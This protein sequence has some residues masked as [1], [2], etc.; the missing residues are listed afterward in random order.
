MGK[1]A[2]MAM[3][4]VDAYE[5]EWIFFN[6]VITQHPPFFLVGFGGNWSL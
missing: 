2:A 1:M 6:S 3:L 5:G 4:F